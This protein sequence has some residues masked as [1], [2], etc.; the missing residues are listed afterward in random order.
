[1]H[2]IADL[3]LGTVADEFGGGTSIDNVVLQRVDELFIRLHSI[4]IADERLCANKELGAGGSII[5][6]RNIRID[7]V[8][9]DQLITSG[10]IKRWIGRLIMFLKDRAH[11]N[12]RIL[13]RGSKGAL[14]DIHW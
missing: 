3:N 2:L 14:D 5:N 1:M 12:A 9:G 4:H 11:R 13:G 10:N 7:G 8:S 6:G